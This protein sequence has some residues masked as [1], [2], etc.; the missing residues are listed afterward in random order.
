MEIRGL[1]KWDLWRKMKGRGKRELGEWYRRKEGRGNGKEG[2]RV[3][4]GNVKEEGRE[5]SGNVKEGLRDGDSNLTDIKK[6][7]TPGRETLW[8]LSANM[9]IRIFYFLFFFYLV[10]TY[11]FIF[12]TYLF[13]KEIHVLVSASFAQ[14]LV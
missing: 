13:G 1:E 10:K 12:P 14:V 5:G 4:N 8:I 3:G 6:D 9:G 7:Q 2:G 11:E